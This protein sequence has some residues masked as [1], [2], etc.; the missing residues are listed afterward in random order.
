MQESRA[1]VRVL[2]SFV[3]RLLSGLSLYL[4]LERVLV[5]SVFVRLF[6][7]HSLLLP[8]FSSRILL[9][10]LFIR[11]S[12]CPAAARCCSSAAAAA[13]AGAAV[14]AAAAAAAANAAAALFSSSVPLCCCGCFCLFLVHLTFTGHTPIARWIHTHTPTFDC[15]PIYR[16]VRW[17][18]RPQPRPSHS[19]PL[20]PP[21]PLPLPRPIPAAPSSSA[22]SHAPVPSASSPRPRL[23]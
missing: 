17:D 13:A 23:G 7:L 5:L 20:T 15:F 12:A 18:L 22:P 9:R 21:P 2:S 1:R 10:F 19:S 6:D 8:C 14:A 4:L 16:S 3:V 11:S